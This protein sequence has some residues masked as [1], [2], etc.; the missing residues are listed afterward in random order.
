[1]QDINTSALSRRGF[2]GGA[3]AVAAGALA[4]G[5]AGCAPQTPADNQMAATGSNAG[6]PETWDWEADVIVVGAGGAGHMAAIAAVEEGGSAIMFE[7]MSSPMGDTAVCA[8]EMCGPWPARTKADSGEEDTI[9]QY[10]EDWKNSAKWST[11]TYITGEEFDGERVLTQREIELCPDTFQWL[12]DEAGVQWTTFYDSSWDPQPKWETV[13]PRNW[14]AN[15]TRLIPPLVAKAADLG[16]ETVFD[17]P[18]NQLLLD[19]NGRVV[20]IRLYSSSKG[21]VH[22]KANK[23]VVVTTGSFMREGSMVSTYAPDLIYSMAGC[24]PGA[25]GDGH[26]MVRDIGGAWTSMDH[27]FRWAPVE[28]G[29]YSQAMMGSWFYCGITKPQVPGIFINLEDKRYA[30]ESIGYSF[31]AYEIYQQPFHL[32]Y[33]VV[34]SVGAENTHLFE[35]HDVSTAGSDTGSPMILCQ[36]DTIEELAVKMNVDPATLKSE[37]DRYNGFVA[38]GVDEDFGKVM[39]GTTPIEVGPFYALLEA[40]APYNTYDGIQTDVDS[41]VLDVRGEVIPGLYAAGSCCGSYAEQEGLY[42]TGGVVQAMCFGR[43][44]GKNAMAE[45]AQA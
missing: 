38:K 35:S 40:P 6:L 9:E 19:E 29:V 23:A 41:H 43:Q 15:E 24:S 22:A 13:K 42:Y 37:V 3:A 34:D 44:A 20:G 1:M 27:G 30:A 32:A 33:W 18:A 11:K 7:K 21:I 17:T 10:M 5:M 4:A 28:A 16:I 12:Q 25:S 31:S 39:D 8:C 26:K 36:A 45:E 14:K 2:I